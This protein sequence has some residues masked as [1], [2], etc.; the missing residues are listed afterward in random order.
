[1]P[2]NLASRRDDA[3]GVASGVIQFAWVRF[4]M[5][6]QFRQ[7][8]GWHRRMCHQEE[9]EEA[10]VADRCEIGDNIVR[11]LLLKVGHS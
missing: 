4:S 3:C 9:R 8:F 5:G 2:A 11:L 7:G 10:D 6:D 1:M